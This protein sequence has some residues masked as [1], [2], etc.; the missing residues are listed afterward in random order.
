MHSDT[1]PRFKDSKKRGHNRDRRPERREE[2]PGRQP[3]SPCRRGSTQSRNA[4]NADRKESP[5]FEAEGSIVADSKQE[6]RERE[7]A[8]SKP[9]RAARIPPLTARN[10]SPFRT[11]RR[12]PERNRQRHQL[13][14]PAPSPAPFPSTSRRAPRQ[15]PH[16]RSPSAPESHT[17]SAWRTMQERAPELQN[18]SKPADSGIQGRGEDGAQLDS[19][20]IFFLNHYSTGPGKHKPARARRV[21]LRMS[22]AFTNEVR[23]NTVAAN[24]T[25]LPRLSL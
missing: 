9:A 10:R 24:Q 25:F 23:A 19:Y 11:G 3:V 5:R 18:V 6:E 20:P 15:C 17:R 14:P 7:P 1:V 8:R 12:H 16:P 21:C 4:R 2:S 13:P 22:R